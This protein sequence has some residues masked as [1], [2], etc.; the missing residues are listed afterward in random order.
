MDIT[1]DLTGTKP[2]FR[3]LL[4]IG[5]YQ[6]RKTRR[7]IEILRFLEV[8]GARGIRTPDPLHAM[9]MRYQ[10]RHSPELHLC[11]SF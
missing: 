2:K 3:K 1:L 5:N 6:I 7:I 11:G 4:S 10:L 8:C 9:E